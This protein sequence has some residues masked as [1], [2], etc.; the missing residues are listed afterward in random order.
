[1]W[2]N[3]ALSSF[4]NSMCRL[5]GNTLKSSRMFPCVDL[6]PM[7]SRSDWWRFQT[8][9]G[10][11]VAAERWNT[12][13]CFWSVGEECGRLLA[14]VTF[15][16]RGRE[17][18]RRWPRLFS[19]AE[20]SAGHRSSTAFTVIMVFIF[21][22]V[23]VLS[24]SFTLYLC[25]SLCVGEATLKLNFHLATLYFTFIILK[26]FFEMNCLNEPICSSEPAH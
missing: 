25:H 20:L 13:C 19:C 6:F 18:S 9:T 24:L 14:A 15:R 26:Q 4:L 11:G 8:L 10:A 17:R 7:E 21:L 12:V 5:W 23:P 2:R 1:M 16:K 3:C 22:S